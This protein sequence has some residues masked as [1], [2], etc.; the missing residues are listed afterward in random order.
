MG[1]QVFNDSD[2]IIYYI[3]TSLALKSKDEGRVIGILK[4][5]LSSPC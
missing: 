1:K 5:D 4:G 2:Y 3:K